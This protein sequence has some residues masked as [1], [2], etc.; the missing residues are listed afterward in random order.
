MKTPSILKGL[1]VGEGVVVG[2][3]YIF[4]KSEFKVTK[5]SSSLVDEEVYFFKSVEEKAIKQID[6]LIVL[7]SKNISEEK[8]DIFRAHREIL[9]DEVIREEI[10]KVI[11]EEKCCLA[12]VKE[13]GGEGV[14]LFRTEFLYMKSSQWPSEES[15][16]ES[17][18]EALRELGDRGKLTIRTLDIGGDKSLDY[19]SFP[20]EM[21]PFLGY[22]AIRMSLRETEAFTTQIRAILRASKEGEI[23]VMFPMITTYEEFME[24]KRIFNETKSKLE[25][26]GHSFSKEVS[27]G[28]MIEVPGAALIS[29]LL[30]ESADFMSIGSNDL[31]QYTNAVDRM[32]ENVNSL[33]Q[34]NSPGVLRLISIVAQS[35]KKSK[36]EVSVCGEMASNPISAVLLLG[37][38]ISKLSMSASSIP[39]IKRVLSNIDYQEA[40]KI[41]KKALVL[42]TE[43]EVKSLVIEFL[44]KYNVLI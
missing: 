5:E 40:Q 12:Q 11:K 34:P 9:K 35:G 7:A 29:D 36:C 1:G 25:S 41:S 39:V 4:Q 10:V 31:I 2:K 24:A 21:N 44:E 15:Q 19:Y 32:S 3:A 28:L 14:G 30:A 42:K 38:G 27:V 22:R 8:A 37:L 18:V 23:N 33:Y 26:E 17:Y 16:Y 13:F 20:D 6:E 43:A